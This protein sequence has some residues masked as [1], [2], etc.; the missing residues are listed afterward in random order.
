V[1]LDIKII[2]SNYL[3][4]NELTSCILE[5]ELVVIKDNNCSISLIVREEVCLVWL[6][7]VLL[8]LTVNDYWSELSSLSSNEVSELSSA[9]VVSVIEKE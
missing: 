2:L 9:V 5:C 6:E 8:V 4:I 3:I 7:S 1:S